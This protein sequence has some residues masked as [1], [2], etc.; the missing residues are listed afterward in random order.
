MRIRCERDENFDSFRKSETDE[1]RRISLLSEK[2]EIH[3]TPE[4]GSW[5]NMAEI[6]SSVLSRQCLQRRVPGFQKH[7]AEATAWQERRDAAG[8][9]IEWR[10]RTDEGR[11]KLR[12]LY[13]SP[14]E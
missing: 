7:K 8:V 13:P 5:P 9:K 11:T 3:H 14:Q 4:H 1:V 6:E 12:R 10:F 2:L